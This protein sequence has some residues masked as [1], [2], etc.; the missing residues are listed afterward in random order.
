MNQVRRQ[1]ALAPVSFQPAARINFLPADFDGAEAPKPGEPNFYLE[2]GASTYLSLWQFHVDFA[3]PSSSTFTHTATLPYS[4]FSL[5][6]SRNPPVW[7][8]PVI[9]QPNTSELLL[10][11]PDQLMY[12]LAWRN[13]GGT[14]HLVTNET[15]ILQSSP[16]VAGVVWFD[17]VN[18]AASAELAQY[19]T[20]SDPAM[21]N[22]YWI[23]SLAQ[24]QDGDIALGFNASSASLYPSIDLAGRLESGQAGAMTLLGPLVTG[25]GSQTNTSLWG[26][27]ADMSLDP[28]NDCVFWFTGEYVKTTSSGFDWN[29]R[30]GS[31]EFTT[32]Q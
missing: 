10:A 25:T 21:V 20:V 26:T 23:G 32:C 15:V 16:V 7:G 9:P 13:V 5:G 17:V 12:R 30:I 28:T 27:H 11:Y 1:T 2:V 14:E 22:S 6:C 29:T 19:G 24:D 31:F 4:V 3:D 18:P 8:S